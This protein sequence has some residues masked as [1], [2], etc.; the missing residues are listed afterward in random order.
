ML[1]NYWDPG[2][3]PNGISRDSANWDIEYTGDTTLDP[4]DID[5][6][7]IK[8]GD[9]GIYYAGI[10]EDKCLGLSPT[11]LIVPLS[12]A[13]CLEQRFT[14]C[15]HQ[16]CYTKQGDEC[17]FPFTYKGNPHT[18]CISE[19]V[20]LPWCATEMSGANIVRWGLCL[21]D[22]EHEVPLPSCLAPPPV[23][24]FGLRDEDGIITHQN[25]MSSWFF[26]TFIGDAATDVSI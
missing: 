4:A 14:V 26:L 23:P 7:I 18:K 10:T 24:D 5:V 16:S 19:D 15:E 22:C 1:F 8:T 3:D 20:Y 13:E 12:G 9:M 21:D 11:G 2:H 17:V 25:Y 6:V